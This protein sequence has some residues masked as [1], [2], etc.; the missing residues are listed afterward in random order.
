VRKSAQQSPE[1]D[2]SLAAMRLLFDKAEQNQR[3]SRDSLLLSSLVTSANEAAED[4]AAAELPYGRYHPVSALLVRQAM[5]SYVPQ[6]VKVHCYLTL[7]H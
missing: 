2:S 4:P 3:Q 1:T 5:R 7:C 6:W